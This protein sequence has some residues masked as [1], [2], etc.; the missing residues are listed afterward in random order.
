[1][2]DVTYIK[3]KGHRWMEDNAFKKQKQYISLKDSSNV[4][5][6]NNAGSVIE[7]ERKD[8]PLFKWCLE[9]WFNTKEVG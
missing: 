4:V 8:I 5:S 7:V 2:R 1:M 3:I 9:E 6:I